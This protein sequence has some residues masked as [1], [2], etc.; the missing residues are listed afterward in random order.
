MI[1]SE[2]T[3]IRVWMIKNLNPACTISLR[4]AIK[5]EIEKNDAEDTQEFKH[6]FTTLAQW[7]MFIAS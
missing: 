5:T 4:F 3:Q 6:F 1:R 2:G 7:K